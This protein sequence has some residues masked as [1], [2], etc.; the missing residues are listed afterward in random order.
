MAGGDLVTWE[1]LCEDDDNV[2]GGGSRAWKKMIM[3]VC[4][5]LWDFFKVLPKE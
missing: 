3:P 1:Q 4:V 2:L 5:F